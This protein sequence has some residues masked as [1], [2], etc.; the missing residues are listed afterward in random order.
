LN[1]NYP[2][3]HSVFGRLLCIQGRFGEAESAFRR[4]QQLDPLAAGIVSGI[5]L[6]HHMAGNYDRAI[7]EFR[8]AI[9][10]DPKFAPAHFNLGATWAEKGDLDQAVAAYRKGFE[11]S[12]TD[13]GATAEMAHAYASLGRRDE[14]LKLLD[15]VNELAAKRYVDA[16]FFALIHVGLNDTDRALSSLER[17]LQERSQNM[18]YL[19]VDPRFG[20]LRGQ[21]RFT[22]IAAAMKFPG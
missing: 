19:K 5:G 21:P 20:K 8:N 1:H 12:P 17:G 16:W 9:Q 18:I 3:T 15:R 14:A 2:S 10:L 4:A 22:R 13:A 6:N 7:A 11:I